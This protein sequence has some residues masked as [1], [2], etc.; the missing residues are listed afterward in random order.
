MPAST[1]P[2]PDNALP[3]TAID[4]GSGTWQAP[5]LGSEQNVIV[6]APPGPLFA[7]RMIS[8]T[9]PSS[10][11]I[12]LKNGV[13]AFHGAPGVKNHRAA[14]SQNGSFSLPQGVLAGST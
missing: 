9:E 6:A 3:R 4:A 1:P 13:P 8:L 7:R 12:V 14:G 2:M 11:R 5:T 10:S